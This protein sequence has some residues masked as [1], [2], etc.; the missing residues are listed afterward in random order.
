MRPSL[1][2]SCF[3][4]CRVLNRS[5][6]ELLGDIRSGIVLLLQLS[7]GGDFTID[8]AVLNSDL[9]GMVGSTLAVRVR[10]F[11]LQTLD[12]LLSL[13]DVLHKSVSTSTSPVN[14]CINSC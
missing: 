4:S 2:R 7:F 5:L 13:L 8:T 3:S 10:L 9:L 14:I 12:L 11:L 1:Y 6:L